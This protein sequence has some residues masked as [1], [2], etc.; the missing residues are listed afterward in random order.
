MSKAFALLPISE[1]KELTP[2]L[3]EKKPLL[4]SSSTA[5]V[6]EAL[7]RAI[8]TKNS[9]EIQQA[10]D[11]KA[12][13]NAVDNNMGTPLFYAITTAEVKEI[14]YLINKGADILGM[15]LNAISVMHWALALDMSSAQNLPKVQCLLQQVNPA[16]PDR[17]KIWIQR[18]KRYWEDSDQRERA[19]DVIASHLMGFNIT[20]LY[21]RDKGDLSK[22]LGH[23]NQ[24]EGETKG[25]THSVSL[26][27]WS[28]DHFLAL[29][30]R[31]LISF[32]LENS[33][34][35]EKK[36]MIDDIV[37][38]LRIN[39][40]TYFV[41]DI[42][43]RIAKITNS[44]PQF[45]LYAALAE[46]VCK[47]LYAL[48]DHGQYCLAVGW[49]KHAIYL[50]FIRH[51]ENLYLRVDNFGAG[52]ELYF[53]KHQAKYQDKQ[54][55]AA[56]SV[57]LAKI[58]RDE[59]KHSGDFSL[60]NY[61]AELLSN[62][63]KEAETNHKHIKRIYDDEKSYFKD[64]WPTHLLGEW[65]HFPTQ[66]G[67]HCSHYNFQQ[68]AVMRRSPTLIRDLKGAEHKF[69]SLAEDRGVQ[70]DLLNTVLAKELRES[71]QILPTRLITRIRREYQDQHMER[72][73]GEVVPFSDLY[74]ELTLVESGD[75]KLDIMSLTP[76]T[77]LIP[78]EAPPLENWFSESPAITEKILLTGAAGN[79]KSTF[80][81]AA[82]IRWAKNPMW[83]DRF[84]LVS[85]IPLRF[86][87]DYVNKNKVDQLI[88]VLAQAGFLSTSPL[89]IL[90]K[91][92]LQVTINA[93]KVLF[94]LDGADEMPD[95]LTEPLKSM[96]DQLRAGAH[97]ITCRPYRIP[98]G[99]LTH[100]LEIKGFNPA[101]IKQYVDKFFQLINNDSA[102]GV[103]L[104]AL[105]KNRE[106]I[107]LCRSPFLLEISCY[108]QAQE[109]LDVKE[110]DSKGQQS[111]VKIKTFS[112][113]TM[114]DLCHDIVG[115]L[116]MQSVS[117]HFPTDKTSTTL[118]NVA[119]HPHAQNM[120]KFLGTLA[121]ENMASEQ[122]TCS[123]T[124]L[125][126]ALRS[127]GFFRKTAQSLLQSS[128]LKATTVD[129]QGISGCYFSQPY[130]QDFCLALQIVRG[131]V[132]PSAGQT[133]T[134]IQRYRYRVAYQSVWKLVAGLLRHFVTYA[135]EETIFSVADS[136]KALKIFFDALLGDSFELGWYELTLIIH[137]MEEYIHASAALN[138]FPLPIDTF[139]RE[140]IA[141]LV[142]SEPGKFFF[143][144][145]VLSVLGKSPGILTQTELVD[146]LSQ[147]LKS[148]NPRRVIR[149]THCLV[150]MDCLSSDLL[151][152]AVESLLNCLEDVSSELP[153]KEKALVALA[154]LIKI[155]PQKF[156]QRIETVSWNCLVS[157]SP[158]IRQVSE[159]ILMQYFQHFVGEKLE[160]FFI[161][162]TLKSKTIEGKLEELT[163]IQSI[164]RFCS[165]KLANALINPL[166][167]LWKKIHQE[168]SLSVSDEQ[169]HLL[170]YALGIVCQRSTLDSVYNAILGKFSLESSL[171]LNAV[172][173]L[174]ASG[175][176]CTHP[177]IVQLIQE[178]KPAPLLVMALWEQLNRKEQD[179]KLS[180][181]WISYLVE[182]MPE[183]LHDLSPQSWQDHLAEI[184]WRDDTGQSGFSEKLRYLP[185]LLLFQIS[186]ALE[187]E[188]PLVIQTFF[189][190]ASASG[191]AFRYV[192]GTLL[193]YSPSGEA[194]AYLVI[195]AHV[196]AFTKAVETFKKSSKLL[197]WRN[198]E[199]ISMGFE[200]SATHTT[201][202][203]I[204]QKS[205]I[206]SAAT[207]IQSTKKRKHSSTLFP[208]E[209]PS[210]VSSSSSA[211]S[212]SSSLT[213]TSRFTNY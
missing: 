79:G 32:L 110:S 137:C 157:N 120:M 167:Q 75:Q 95:E 5:S 35:L 72:L 115:W 43:S 165:S 80:C 4:P 140:L 71:A 52:L 109:M 176:R 169:K 172:I 209:G 28:P 175:E 114:T 55:I 144:E 121:L 98:T 150:M 160:K 73:N 205:E 37:D 26:A 123:L 51:G 141:M 126:S 91:E 190:R 198:W 185:F 124:T 78:K 10:L 212:S 100:R 40:E 189:E 180:A 135:G 129:S 213:S 153:L 117:K 127:N 56:R 15:N 142:T 211:S 170:A 208:T 12:D 202:M 69:I 148:D 179:I 70:K 182:S 13:I 87:V 105:Q 84:E 200:S 64:R 93:G 41:T 82:L 155:V 112:S 9:T 204:E 27:H 24:L 97:I 184:S 83:T 61:I 107:I 88:D 119:T 6:Q 62:R 34:E 186:A 130:F 128:L 125:D 118:E 11:Q 197:L 159:R 57:V 21:D 133:V 147:E 152:S 145:Q 158:E 194:K 33:A 199:K 53:E 171:A 104:N 23:L 134:L 111:M 99:T 106:W 108:L 85:L 94:V 46:Y 139:C 19:L 146:Q 66:K 36:A 42:S 92:L 8:K 168:M 113:R 38:E 201:V 154:Q 58:P 132:S 143:P 39:L 163:N 103:F 131:L 196:G 86:L 3:D 25:T 90:E 47:N 101:T 192:P 149:A 17:L 22:Y 29:R 50:V 193:V 16:D 162:L 7:F 60:H 188:E 210:L 59:I 74:T 122:K 49:E 14:Q 164:I 20:S 76:S 174:A 183:R 30:V 206:S 156:K 181:P 116:L 89:S 96:Y 45:R 173:V 178:Q 77:M 203:E 81:H 166:N 136:K 207:A 63:M 68:G 2:S 191:L 161:F 65:P 102:K 31:V 54:M 67:D 138:L 151:V 44:I 187:H 1:S 48:K 195:G 177:Q 18:G